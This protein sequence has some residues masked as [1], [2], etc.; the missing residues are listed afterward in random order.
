MVVKSMVATEDEVVLNLMGSDI[1]ES[2]IVKI[3]NL[4]R[5]T[6][7]ENMVSVDYLVEEYLE[8]SDY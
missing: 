4:V 3:L 1:H 6:K 2:Q 8:C 5:D 7:K